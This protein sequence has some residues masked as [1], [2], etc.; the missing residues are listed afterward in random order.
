MAAATFSV[1]ESCSTNCWPVASRSGADT[2]A[3][4]LEQVTSYEAKPLRQFDEKLPK[5]LE[6]I[7][8]KAMAKRASERYS[9]ATRSGR[10][11]AALLA[12]AVMAS[13]ISPG[14]MARSPRKQRVAPASRRLARRRFQCPRRPA[15]SPTVSP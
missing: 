6:R 1:W 14:R 9:S 4:L 12:Q 10:R 8:Q 11:P 13:G 2:R 5:E 7:C 3:E 15:R